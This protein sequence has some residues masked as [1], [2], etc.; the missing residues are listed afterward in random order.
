MKKNIFMYA[1]LLIIAVIIFLL[2]RF[3][4]MKEYEFKTIDVKQYNELKMDNNL[5]VI[6]ITG[7][8]YYIDAFDKILLKISEEKDTKFN[9]LDI[10]DE[11]NFNSLLSDE[12]FMN[13]FSDSP[14]FPNVIILE[15]GEIKGNITYDTEENIRQKL[16]DLG[17][18]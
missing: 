18:E 9:K 17:V 5:N 14:I 15:N 1:I 12:Q 10:T 7:N 16:I 11:E 13:E 3:V 4:F 2:I 6:Y 8:E